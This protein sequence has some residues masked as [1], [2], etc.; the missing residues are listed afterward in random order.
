MKYIGI[1]P[2]IDKS[3]IAIWDSSRGSF[4]F[5]STQSFYDL[6]DTLLMNK[7]SYVRIEAG[8]L[9]K[10]SNYHV[11]KSKGISDAISRKVGE[12][13]MIGKL[14]ERFCIRNN[15]KYQLIKPSTKKYNSITFT[16]TT[17]VK[18]RTNQEVRDAAMLVF[19][20]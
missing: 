6:L 16:K 1:D 12:N 11:A 20:F 14:I 15:I 19:G 7:E 4:D 5:L 2:D 8:W 10:K 9:N 3:G 13:H 18:G 17:G